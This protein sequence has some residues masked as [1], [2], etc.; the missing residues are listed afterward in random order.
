[1]AK[2]TKSARLWAMTFRLAPDETIRRPLWEFPPNACEALKHERRRR[3]KWD[4]DSEGE[5]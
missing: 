2:L 5:R 3:F 1:M 4:I